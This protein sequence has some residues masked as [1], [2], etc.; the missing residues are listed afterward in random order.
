LSI[1]AVLIVATNAAVESL[2][3][4]LAIVVQAVILICVPVA[5]A[6]I[7]RAQAPA[8]IACSRTPRLL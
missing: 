3:I 5:L 8:F 4:R 1:E 6:D 2:S 7:L